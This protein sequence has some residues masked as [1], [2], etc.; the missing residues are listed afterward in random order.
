MFFYAL[1]DSL[2][3]KINYFQST[4]PT[5]GTYALQINIYFFSS[6]FTSTLLRK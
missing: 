3:L 6:N 5:R 4:Y 1:L 2:R